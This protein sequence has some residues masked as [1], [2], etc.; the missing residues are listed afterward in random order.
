[1][2]AQRANA[3]GTQQF[4]IGRRGYMSNWLINATSATAARSRSRSTETKSSAY[5][6]HFE[7]AVRLPYQDMLSH[8]A[9]QLDTLADR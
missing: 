5:Q 6:S 1:M 7:E 3:P 2:L 8:H 9:I 4:G